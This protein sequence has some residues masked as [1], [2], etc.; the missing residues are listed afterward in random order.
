M[1]TTVDEHLALLGFKVK[2]VVSGF[3]GVVESISF[4][5]YGCVRAVVSAQVAKE[6]KEGLKLGDSHYFDL[7]RLQAVSDGPVM[8]VPT[9]AAP[10]GG[11]GLPPLSSRA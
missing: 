10:P 2:D 8:T 4:D 7:K 9:F 5:L 6:S 11:I 1:E 3:E